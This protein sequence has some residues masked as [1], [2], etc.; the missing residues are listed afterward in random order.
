MS[1]ENIK[2]SSN[3]EYH[4]EGQHYDLQLPCNSST[5]HKRLQRRLAMTL[6]PLST[7]WNQADKGPM[8]DSLKLLFESVNPCMISESHDCPLPSDISLQQ[9]ASDIVGAGFQW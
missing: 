3:L 6:M 1:G 4:E 8:S 7:L 2:A 5:M 9:S